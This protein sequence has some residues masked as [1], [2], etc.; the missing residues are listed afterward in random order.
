MS[1]LRTV[2]G[3]ALE[4][5]KAAVPDA[6]IIESDLAAELAQLVHERFRDRLVAGEGGL[7]DLAHQQPQR[8][9][10]VAHAATRSSISSRDPSD[11]AEMLK[12]TFCPRPAS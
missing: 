1:I 2:I 10:G 11:L 5:R 6:E 12:C 8:G 9:A 4:V 7:G 3:K